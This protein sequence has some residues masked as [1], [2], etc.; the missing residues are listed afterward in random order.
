[1]TNPWLSSKYLSNFQ[2]PKKSMKLPGIIFNNKLK[3]NEQ[4]ANAIKKQINF[5]MQYK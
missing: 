3:W 1:M 2:S 5:F 4:V